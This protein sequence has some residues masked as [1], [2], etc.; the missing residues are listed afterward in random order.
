MAALQDLDKVIEIEP[1]MPNASA[2]CG[3]IRA[4]AENK[5]RACEDYSQAKTNGDKMADNYLHQFGGNKQG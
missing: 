1:T 4:K 5:K 3:Q 2:L